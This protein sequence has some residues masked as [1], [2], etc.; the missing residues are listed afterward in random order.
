MD[1]LN[2]AQN[3]SR[4]PGS[5]KLFIVTSLFVGLQAAVMTGEDP[6]TL[7]WQGATGGDFGTATN[8]NPNGVPQ[9]TETFHDTVQFT[10]EGEMTVSFASDFNVATLNFLGTTSPADITPKL[11]LD[12]DGNSLA[13][14]STAT[15]LLQSTTAIGPRELVVD[16]GT[17][18]IA[19]DFDIQPNASGQSILRLTNGA[20]FNQNGGNANRVGGSNAS[21]RGELIVEQGST[22]TFSSRIRVAPGGGNSQISISGVGSLAQG[23]LIQFQGDAGGLSVTD[24]GRLEA[25]RIEIF[26]SSSLMTFEVSGVGIDPEDGVTEVASRAV[27]SGGVV[28]DSVASGGIVRVADGGILET[29]YLGV[30]SNGR[31][32][33]DGGQILLSGADISSVIDFQSGATVSFLLS[34]PAQSAG[35]I[36]TG[37]VNDSRTIS[38]GAETLLEINLVDGFSANIGDSFLLID[39]SGA[40]DPGS[41]VTGNFSNN[42]FDVD[43]YTFEV[44]YALNGDAIAVTVIP[45]PA[46]VVILSALAAMLCVLFRKRR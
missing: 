4:I 43:G 31:V 14:N 41:T 39:Y 12:L 23:T 10:D 26:R 5:C 28:N 16:G 17:L 15:W 22:F 30:G 46:A 44:N 6:R 25:N 36:Y 20:T 42:I 18:S 13:L 38:I 1:A 2:Y 3:S 32:D 9:Y 40:S 19:G 8:W 7:V 37:S 35:M 34:S 33:V 11:T 21:R 45:E 24:G 27:I 29:G